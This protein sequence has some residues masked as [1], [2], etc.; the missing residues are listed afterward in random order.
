[1]S[2]RELLIISRLKKHAFVLVIMPACAQPCQI[3]QGS[4][5]GGEGELLGSAGDGGWGLKP[6]GPHWS[7]QPSSTGDRLCAEV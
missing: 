6:D 3:A 7:P 2:C 5:D 1:M 4:G